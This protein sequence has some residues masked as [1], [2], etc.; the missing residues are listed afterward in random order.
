MLEHDRGFEQLVARNQGWLLRYVRKIVGSQEAAEDIVQE[1]FIRAYKAYNGYQETGRERQWLRT[2]ARNVALR[3]LG[4]PAAKREV[5]L[6]TSDESIVDFVETALDPVPSAEE[7]ALANELTR[8]IIDAIS[9]LPEAQRTVVYYRFVMNVSVHQV[10]YL[11]NQPVGSVKSKC[12]YGLQKLRRLLSDYMIEGEYVVNCKEAYVFL[13]QYAKGQIMREDREKV[14]GHLD[15]C[16]DCNDL[17]ESLR[18]LAAS[19]TPAQDGEIRHYMIAMPL[20]DGTNLLYSGVTYPIDDHQRD[21]MN[22]VLQAN[23]G[24]I[25]QKESWSFTSHDANLEHLAEFDNE[26][27][28]IEFELVPKPSDPS[29]VMVV[30]RKMVK[31]YPEHLMASVALSKDKYV[32]TTIEDPNLVVGKMQ[33]YLGVNAK[34]GLYLAIPAGAKNIRIRRGNGVIDAGAYKFAFS[35]RYVAEDECLRLEC[36][37]LKS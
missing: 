1:T 18:I 29:K 32:T 16:K 34:S 30:Y 7:V 3:Y 36:T 14:E 35:E 26:G 4:D 37:Y 9:K 21:H 19:M 2:I 20:S 27:H 28:R 10:A 17:A 8:R 6:C 24:A 23:G 11:T 5:N 22:A 25:P 15:A 12:H 13:F 33:N 31:V